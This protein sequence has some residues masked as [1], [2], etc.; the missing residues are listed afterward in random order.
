LSQNDEEEVMKRKVWAVGFGLWILP[1]ITASSYSQITF[2]RTYGGSEDDK[3]YSV[4]QTSDGGYIITGS[5]RSYRPGWEDVYLI[6][7]DSLGD[8]LWTKTFG[9]TSQDFGYSVMQTTDGG[10]IITGEY[11][12]LGSVAPNAYLIKTD[13]LGNSLW[14]RTYVDTLPSLPDAKGRSVQQTSD[15]GYI[16]AGHIWPI[17]C[18]ADCWEILLIKTDS[19]GDTLW[20]KSYGGTDVYY[21]SSVQQTTDGGYIIAGE[22]YFFGSGMRDALLIKTDPTGETLWTKSFGGILSDYFRS[23]KQ[24]ADGGFIITGSTSSFGAGES[25]VYL[26]KTDSLGDTL[27]TRTYGGIA[28]DYGFSVQQTASGG[29][30]ITGETWSFGAGNFDLY[31]IET[32]ASG[33]TL[34]TRTYG[35]DGSDHG[36]SVCQT[37]GMADVYLIKTD[38]NGLVGVEEESSDFKVGNSRVVLLQN[39]PNPFNFR[40]MIQYQIPNTGYISLKFYDLS[41]RLVETL[42]DERQEPGVYQV[43]WEGKDQAS[44]VYF[45]N[46]S[47]GEFTT[48]KKMIILR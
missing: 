38:G 25:D 24:T 28:R 48:T 46:L 22:T 35:R 21:G 2:E 33:E 9:G 44:G 45:L 4:K 3:G 19:L 12:N 41:G 15:G 20:T 11:G 8:E 23:V 29:Y 40:T 5:T 39:H 47:V 37:Q 17:G 18:S 30:V 26:I 42:V 14:A 31:L 32:N 6:K 16:I 43:Q 1:F 13:S 34:W 36:F 7:T 10:Y 27:W